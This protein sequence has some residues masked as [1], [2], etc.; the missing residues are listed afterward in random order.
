[1]EHETD[2]TRHLV[3]NTLSWA[4]I[5]GSK[6][7]K[8]TNFS[9]YDIIITTFETL[10]SENKK[11]QDPKSTKCC[12]DTIFS[13]FWHRIVLDEGTWH[14]DTESLM[15]IYCPAHT[16]RNR[17]TAMARAAC[18]VRAT[19]RWAITGTPIQNRVTDFS[20]LLE[21]L[22][23]H[24]FSDP[25][26]FDAEVARPWLKSAEKDSSRLKML[27]RCISLCRSKKVI[28]LPPRV[29][30]V[31]YL[32]FSPSEQSWYDQARKGTIQRLDEALSSNPLKSGQYLNALQWLNELRLICNHGLAQRSR[33]PSKSVGISPGS[34]Q[35]WNKSKASKAF[36]EIVSAG[37]ATCSVC[38]NSLLAGAYSEQSIDSAKPFLSECLIATCGSCAK[39]CLDGRTGIYCPHTPSCKSV[40]VSWVGDSIGPNTSR[41]LADIPAE[42]VSTKLK[43]LLKDLQLCTAGEKRFEPCIAI[44]PLPTA[45]FQQCCLLIL[46]IHTRPH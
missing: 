18:T 17:S 13:F 31:R 33:T 8:T 42:H 43:A 36:E 39:D 38:G 1:M 23:V 46:D 25:K 14:N 44:S 4:R 5:H 37:E 19:S 41:T 27:V 26:I 28:D 45:N 40:E 34:T 15:L 7:R 21:F 12:K 2:I 11:Q 10:V 32:D 6:K 29:D 3:P 30:L 16:I 9:Q 35:V 22:K 20:S 24:P